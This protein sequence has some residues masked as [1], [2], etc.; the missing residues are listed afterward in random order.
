[1]ALNYVDTA[2]PYHRETSETFLVRA[3]QDGYRERIKLATKMPC[4]KMEKFE[5]FDRFLDEQLGKLQTDHIGFYPLYSLDAKSWPKV[6]DLGVLRW[7]EGA[8]AD[9]R[10]GHLGFVSSPWQHSGPDYGYRALSTGERTAWLPGRE[11]LCTFAQGKKPENSWPAFLSWIAGD[12]FTIVRR[13]ESLFSNGWGYSAR[14]DIAIWSRSWMQ[15]ANQRSTSWPCTGSAGAWKTRMRL[16][17]TCPDSPTFGQ[18][19]AE[20][21]LAGG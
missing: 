3:L 21:P 2:Y 18:P 5:D 16:R 19:L 10:I 12:D 8:L 14:T 6:R 9:G 7:A 1:M 17:N 13:G 20:D 4:W 11:N 15:N